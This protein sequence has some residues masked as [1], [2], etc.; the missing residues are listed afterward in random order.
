M[1]LLSRTA[2]MLFAATAA[3]LAGCG[4]LVPPVPMP[5]SAQI[6]PEAPQVAAVALG[7]VA[8]PPAA[9][10]DR[11]V[12]RLDDET[13][14]AGIVLLNYERAGGDYRLEC[15]LKIARRKNIITVTY[16][17]RL[18]TRDGSLAG[19]SSGMEAIAA[20]GANP[21]SLGP[22]PRHRASTHCGARGRRGRKPPS[23]PFLDSAMQFNLKLID[24]DDT[25]VSL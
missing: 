22:N 6:R 4:S 17:W 20:P 15:G 18:I 1:R 23:M 21:D 2:A 7:D 14:R 8:G 3:E 12:H 25:R 5:G 13:R 10:S 11:L 16:E 19:R 24:A 9:V